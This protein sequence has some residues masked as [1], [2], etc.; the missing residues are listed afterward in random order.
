MKT[1]AQSV[2]SDIS[3]VTYGSNTHP[4]KQATPKKQKALL[5]SLSAHS[6]C[7]EEQIVLLSVDEILSTHSTPP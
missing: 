5:M 7:C 3:G 4:F 1:S 2:P 6:E